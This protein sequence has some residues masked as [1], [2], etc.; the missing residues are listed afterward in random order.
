[1]TERPHGW[2]ELQQLRNR[3]RL[4]VEAHIQASDEIHG[5]MIGAANQSLVALQDRLIIAKSGFQAGAV[6]GNRVTTFPYTDI[7]SIEANAGMVN[8]VV[9]IL[10]AAYSG[11]QEKDFWSA[12]RDR[13]PFKAN[14]CLPTTK[15][16]LASA[17]PFLN[18]V[19][20]MIAQAKR[21]SARATEVGGGLADQ[22]VKLADLHKSGVLSDEEFNTAKANILRG[23]T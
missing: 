9:E 20:A 19:R 23:D 12:S 18:E 4:A 22:L 8:A 5:V 14:N 15:A 2:N 17:Q 11:G 13:D 7:I 10:T 16:A 3:E 1:M 6:G 21:P